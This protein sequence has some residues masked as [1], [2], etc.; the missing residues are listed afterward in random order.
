MATVPQRAAQK[1]SRQKLS[2]F[3]RPSKFRATMLNH[4]RSALADMSTLFL[5]WIS[6]RTHLPMV[7]EH[8]HSHAEHTH[9]VAVDG[10]CVFFTCRYLY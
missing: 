1:P 6:E 8:K 2:T 4:I 10:G 3:E 5:C 9:V 7:S